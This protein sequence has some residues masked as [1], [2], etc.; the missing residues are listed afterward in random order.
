MRITTKVGDKGSTR[1]FGGEEVW[2]DS[3][4]IEANG[5]LD[6]LTSFIGEAKHYVD[7]EMKGILEEIQNDIYKIMGEI[8]SKGKI[9]G[10]SEE[11]IAWLLKL[12][13]R[14]MEM[15]NLKSFVLPGGTLES[16]KLDVCRTIAR[17]ALRKVL[18]VTRE[19]GI[20]AEAAAYL[21]ALSDLLFLLARVIE[22]ELGKKLLEAARAGQDDEVRILMANGAD[23]NAHDDQGSTPLHL[24]AWIGHPEIVE[25]L[26]KH[27]ADVNARDTDG[28]TPLHLAADNGHLEIVEVLLK[29]GADVNAQDAYGL[30]P[31]HLAAD[32]G[33]LEIVEVL[34][35]HGADVNAQDKFGKTAFDISIDNGNEDLAEI[36]QKLN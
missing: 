2:K 21:L 18:T 10:I 14:Y 35:K 26:L 12:I 34:L 31:L 25:V 4:I 29:Y 17:R 19:F 9:E 33:H 20:G 7:E 13:L 32:R 11:R 3:P 27:G 30:T 5:T 24:A 36:L 15:V 1:L 8:G 23:V 6:E 22:I 16:A 28:W